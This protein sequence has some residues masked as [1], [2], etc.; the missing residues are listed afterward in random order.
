MKFN[1]TVNKSYEVNNKTI[2][3]SRSIAI[4][5][6]IVA[7]DVNMKEPYVLISQRGTGAAD[8][9]GLWN[10]VAGYLDYDE[11]TTEACI[12]ETFEE[13]NINLL[14]ILST[15]KDKNNLVVVNKIDE[16]WGTNS[17]VTNNKQNVS[18][19]YGIYFKMTNFMNKIK[20]SDKNSEPNE[21]ADIKWIPL[22][23]I[24]EYNFAFNHDKL[25]YEFFDK[26]VKK[27]NTFKYF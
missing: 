24:P 21:V 18:F 19:R 25:I 6:V 16:E 7:K 13:T 9:N 20:L 23:K 1:N 3:A 8:F 15:N 5:C 10:V 11:T 2:W 26:Y 22:S 12:R 27:E 17:D 4:N 14:S